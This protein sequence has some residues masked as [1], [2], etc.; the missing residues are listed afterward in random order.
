[1]W[2]APPA[3]AAILFMAVQTNVQP[4]RA[5]ILYRDALLS[6]LEPEAEPAGHIRRA[7]ALQPQEGLYH[8]L[9]SEILAIEGL[10]TVGPSQSQPLFEQ[11][12]QSLATARHLS[13][14]DPAYPAH[15]GRL[16]VRWGARESDARRRA[17]RWAKAVEAYRQALALSPGNVVLWNELGAAELLMGRLDTAL[18]T[19]R[20]SLRL[21][22]A[23]AETHLQLASLYQRLGDED[24][25]V[26]AME[27]ARALIPPERRAVMQELAERQ[28]RF[29][30]F[31]SSVH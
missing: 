13:P 4:V 8:A 9:L 26:R 16:Y 6:V 28:L 21:D 2:V 30:Y 1:V 23:F 10:R 5:N 29:E 27:T 19:L 14:L 3:T 17:D 25:A 18:A 22:S 31:G 11:A 20:H 15:V 24:N 7:I 12:E